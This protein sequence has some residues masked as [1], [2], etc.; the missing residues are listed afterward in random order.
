[1][2]FASSL[3]GPCV[4]GSPRLIYFTLYQ[5]VHF[6]TKFLTLNKLVWCPPIMDTRPVQ[7]G[8]AQRMVDILNNVVYNKGGDNFEYDFADGLPGTGPH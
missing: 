5:K 3:C 1:M 7:S 4:L 8:I 6:S 2:P